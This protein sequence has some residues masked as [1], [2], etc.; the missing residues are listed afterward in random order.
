MSHFSTFEKILHIDLT[1][2]KFLRDQEPAVMG[3]FTGLKI[4]HH[5]YLRHFLDSLKFSKYSYAITNII[6]FCTLQELHNCLMFYSEVFSYDIDP[7]DIK[8]K[9]IYYKKLAQYLTKT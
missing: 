4:K 8:E 2:Y 7:N 1:Q 6:K 5:I 3:L 9:I